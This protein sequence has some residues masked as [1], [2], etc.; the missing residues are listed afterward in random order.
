MNVDGRETL[1]MVYFPEAKSFTDS[2]LASMGTLR[3]KLDC[4]ARVSGTYKIQI[5][6]NGESISDLS[7]PL[8]ERESDSVEIKDARKEDILFIS[9][10]EYSPLN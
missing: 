10:R 5:Y 7:V 2:E 8:P 6:K 1:A 4:M 9:I 3:I